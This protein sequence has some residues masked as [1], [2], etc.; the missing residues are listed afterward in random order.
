M[1]FGSAFLGMSARCWALQAAFALVV[2]L[3]M[4]ARGL[5]VE[6][7]GLASPAIMV[8]MFAGGGAL[9]Y[10]REDLRPLADV[11]FVSVYLT[12]AAALVCVGVQALATLNMPMIDGA[13]AAADRMLGFDQIAF[14]HWLREHDAAARLIGTIYWTT[15]IGAAF[16]VLFCAFHDRGRQLR[17]LIVASVIVLFGS[18]VISGVFPAVGAF[19]YYGIDKTAFP[20]LTSQAGDYHMVAL[21]QLRS[22]ARR[23]LD[24]SN[25]EPIVTFPSFHAALGLISFWAFR[26]VWWLA[27]PAAVF[28]ALVI[29]STLTEGGH[30][31]I[32]IAGG[33]ALFW[34]AVRVTPWFLAETPRKVAAP[35]PAMLPAE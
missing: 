11:L 17:D 24:V 12:V 18:I 13:L 22:G 30:Y 6:L 3:V 27:A 33:A 5:S 23:V 34:F 14:L 16:G 1:G 7:S 2:G 31:I 4:L 8:A 10:R 26:K 32:D 19:P 25:G 15:G 21:E 35:A 20:Y 28:A 9:L 29:V